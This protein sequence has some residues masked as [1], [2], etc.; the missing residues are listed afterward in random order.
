MQLTTTNMMMNRVKNAKI[1]LSQH[2]DLGNRSSLS[3]YEVARLMD[4]IKFGEKAEGNAQDSI[5]FSL[6]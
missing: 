3:V 6:N 1:K 5:F 2:R 4:T